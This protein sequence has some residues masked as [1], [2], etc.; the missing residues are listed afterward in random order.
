MNDNRLVRQNAKLDLWASIRPPLVLHVV[1]RK[2]EACDN[3]RT[4]EFHYRRESRIMTVYACSLTCF[5]ELQQQ[6]E[7]ND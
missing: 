3:V 4:S 5:Q 2:C 1:N 7:K 6:K